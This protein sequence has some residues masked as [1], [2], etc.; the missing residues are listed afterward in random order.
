[1]SSD[2]TSVTATPAADAAMAQQTQQIRP[3]NAGDVQADPAKAKKFDK[4][5]QDYEGVF[6]SQMVSHMSEG[7]GVDP[8]FGG[9]VGEETMK[10]LLTNEYGKMMAARG[11]IGLAAAMKKQLL[12]AQADLAAKQSTAQSVDPGN[13]TATNI[14]SSQEAQP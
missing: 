3:L 11:G 9:G 10:S 5:M 14:D 12:A 2:L 6:L 4:I 7:V 8:L 13:P 1:M